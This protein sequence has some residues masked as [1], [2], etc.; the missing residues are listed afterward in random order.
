MFG[1][2]QR[3]AWPSPG[4]RLS[5]IAR[6]FDLVR[7]MYTRESPWLQRILHSRPGWDRFDRSYGLSNAPRAGVY[8]QPKILRI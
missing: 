1:T 6:G 2:E 3:C 4:V 7:R 5:M 8:C